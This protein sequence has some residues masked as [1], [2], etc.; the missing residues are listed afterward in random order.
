MEGETFFPP[1]GRRADV[2]SSADSTHAPTE[3]PRPKWS[4]ARKV[5]AVLGALILVFVGG[6]VVY[7]YPNGL[8]PEVLSSGGRGQVFLDV[9]LMTFYTPSVPG[10][11]DFNVTLTVVFAT[12]MDFPFGWGNVSGTALPVRFVLTPSPV[13]VSASPSGFVFEEG[14]PGSIGI[15]RPVPPGAFVSL[16]SMAYTVQ[17]LSAWEGFSKTTWFEVDYAL[18]PVSLDFGGYLPIANVTVPGASDLLPTGVVDN[19]NLT[20]QPGYLWTLDRSFSDFTLPSSPFHRTLPPVTFDAGSAGNFTAALT[21]SFQWGKGDD[22][23]VKMSGS[24]TM[25]GS[26]AWYWDRRFGSV[27]TIFS[28]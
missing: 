14:G 1:L 2:S 28:P 24:G 8:P 23:H 21:S 9:A 5:F 20:V 12:G 15:D 11:T 19:L 6:Y 27:F 3:S 22:Y 25:H 4:R 13:F 18:T 10:A 17:E 16:W 7:G 26:L